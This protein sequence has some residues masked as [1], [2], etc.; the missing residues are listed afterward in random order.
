MTMIVSVH[1]GDC[2]L[3]AADKRAM[4]CDLKTGSMRISKDDEKKIKLWTRGA[5]VGTG[6][7]LFLNRIADYFI[8]FKEDGRSLKQM[9][10]IYEEIERR[11]QEGISKE[12]LRNNTI[13]FSI[14]DGTETLLYSIPIDPFFEVTLKNDIEMIHPYMHEIKVWEVNVTC[15]NLPPDMSSLQS[16]QRHLKGLSAFENEKNFIEYYIDKL[17]HVFTTHAFIDPSITPSFDLY[18]QSC[19]T[20]KSLALHVPNLQLSIPSTEKLNFRDKKG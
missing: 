20:G 15:F 12:H 5:I 7:T 18:I 3:I 19:E 2:I 14:F 13:I 9:D 17:K 11:L 16:F 8:Q 1:L 4:V 6:E 10:A